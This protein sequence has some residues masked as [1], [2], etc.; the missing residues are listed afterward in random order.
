MGFDHLP[1]DFVAQLCVGQLGGP[2]AGLAGANSTQIKQ[3][4]RANPPAEANG[5][6][7]RFT[8]VANAVILAASK[9]S[10]G[11][12]RADGRNQR[13]IDGAVLRLDRRGDD[14]LALLKFWS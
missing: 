11:R 2:E 9:S 13:T 5:I 1:R 7:L 3:S 10:G 6:I 14:R 4:A 8:E 12:L